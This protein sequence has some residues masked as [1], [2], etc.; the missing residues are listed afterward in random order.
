MAY[1]MNTLYI[2]NIFKQVAKTLLDPWLDRDELEGIVN[3][4]HLL[5]CVIP[6]QAFN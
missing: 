6:Y 2:E 3:F 5:H 1:I 4:R